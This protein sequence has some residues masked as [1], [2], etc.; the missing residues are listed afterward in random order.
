VSAD[1][2]D[3]R[4]KATDRLRLLRR[5]VGVFGTLLLFDRRAGVFGGLT[6]AVVVV[7]LIVPS[8]DDW[9]IEVD[10]EGAGDEER[11][12]ER[13]CCSRRQV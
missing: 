9:K 1:N 8:D 3:D 6:V 13:I 2:G 7:C 5:T 11:S 12:T 4:E 10:D